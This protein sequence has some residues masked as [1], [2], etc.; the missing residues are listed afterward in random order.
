MVLADERFDVGSHLGRNVLD[1]Q[2]FEVSLPFP[3][4]FGDDCPGK[5]VDLRTE[6]LLVLGLEPFASGLSGR[7][8]R[9]QEC[10]VIEHARGLHCRL[11]EQQAHLLARIQGVGVISE[12]G[13]QVELV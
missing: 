12:Q 3:D 9:L 1:T 13:L 11:I 4:S 5:R 10:D 2:P 7:H 8:P 6:V